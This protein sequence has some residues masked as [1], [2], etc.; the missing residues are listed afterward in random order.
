[1][2]LDVNSLGTIH[3]TAH[4][5]AEQAAA[6]LTKLAD[7]D[8]RVDVTAVSFSTEAD[9]RSSFDGGE[10]VGV[11]LDLAGGPGGRSIVVFDRTGTERLLSLLADSVE[12]DLEGGGGTLSTMERSILAEVGNILNCGFVDGWADVLGTSIDVSPPDLRSGDSA[13]AVLGDIP[14]T[15]DELALSFRSRVETVG[16]EISFRHYLFPDDEAL[17]SVIGPVDTDDGFAFEKLAG[18]D[19]MVERGVSEAA[20]NVA[21][22]TGFET[23]VD[24]HRL[25][26]VPVESIPGEV[27]NEPLVGVAFTFD[28]TP[29][30]HLVFV[31]DEESAREIVEAMLP[32]T[33]DGE[34]GE[35]GR[36]AISELGNIMAS[37][38]LDGWANVL[39]T[40]ID[41]STPTYVHDLGAAVLDP[42]AAEVGRYQEYSFV[43]DARIR[44]NERLFDCQ[45]FA[46]PDARS[47]ER[48]LDA[49]ETENIDRAVE[50]PSFPVQVD[51]TVDEDFEI[52]EE[53]LE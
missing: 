38:F 50:T 42:I 25:T 9:I 49:L 6:R 32:N 24:V 43:F 10:C 35:L 52:D 21:E 29:S 12:S 5:G 47:L 13:G 16:T 40:S 44:A 22:M 4:A 41:H 28:G 34:I 30:G 51:G 20:R 3:R 39:E 31:F 1:M 37:G 33:P 36:S 18:F 7:I 8:T 11:A 26:F 46:V 14:I 2:R 53:L 23:S 19:S 27:S 15:D 17:S 48:A 45:I